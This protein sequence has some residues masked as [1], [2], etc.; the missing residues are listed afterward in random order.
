MLRYKK[1]VSY[2]YSSNPDE[3]T[4]PC[5]CLGTRIAE[6]MY[7]GVDNSHSTLLTGEFD[8][9][10]NWD[11]DPACDMHTDRMDLSIRESIPSSL[12]S[13]TSEE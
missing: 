8:D 13:S 2:S 6:Q 7:N 4:T 10:D 12:S 3:V 1:C 9:D 5:V 11:V